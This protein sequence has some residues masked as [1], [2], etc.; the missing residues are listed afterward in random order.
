MITS[1]KSPKESN[2]T[3]V[4]LIDLSK[5]PTHDGTQTL[6]KLSWNFGIGTYDVQRSEKS[7]ESLKLEFKDANVKKIIS[8]QPNPARRTIEYI[9]HKV[10]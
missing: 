10:R 3:T 4:T 6:V 5:N 9:K 1:P 2:I 7:V 8:K